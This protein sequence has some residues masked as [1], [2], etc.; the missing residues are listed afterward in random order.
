[1]TAA[2]GSQATENSFARD[3]AAARN[4]GYE[5]LGELLDLY[6]NYLLAIANREVGLDVAQ[7]HA[8]SDVVQDTMCQAV[9]DFETFRGHTEHDLRSWLRQILLR[10]ISDAHRRYRDVSKRQLARER[11]LTPSLGGLANSHETPSRL[12]CAVETVQTLHDAIDR[13]P[14]DY[15]QV[16][17]LRNFQQASFDDIGLRLGRSPEAVRKLWSR[18]VQKLAAEL[19]PE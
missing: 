5:G 3:I 12:V 11:P 19:L 1:M 15:R 7:K 17:R 13:L 8:P 2:S 9:R 4:N 6:R 16:I 14:E 10:N 18:A